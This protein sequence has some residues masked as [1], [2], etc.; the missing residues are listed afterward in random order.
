MT[1]TVNHLGISQSERIVWLCEELGLSYKLVIHTRAPLMS[2]ASLTELDGNVTGKAPF[3]T[4]DA[5][6]PPLAL[7]ESNAICEYI[8]DTYGGGK[9][10]IKSGQP[11]YADYLYWFHFNSGTLQP[12]AS[13]AMMVT[14]SNLPKDAFLS[15]SSAKAVQKALTH[16]NNRLESNKWLA[17]ES[18]TAA[19]IMTGYTLSTGRYW[20]AVSLKGYDHILRWLQDVAARPAYQAALKKGD[21]EM[22]PL[23]GANGPEKSLI[24]LGGVTSDV[25]KKK[26]ILTY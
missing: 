5:V 1:I 8:I 22:E 25:W 26:Q 21:P 13:T 15:Q 11:G 3:I 12:T 16:V 20:S 7:S 17:G 4:D 9:F 14:A 19:D 2:P 23:L 6:S 10:K 18:F 24:I